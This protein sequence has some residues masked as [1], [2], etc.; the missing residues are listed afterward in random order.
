SNAASAVSPV[1]TPLTVSTP[2]AGQRTN[3]STP[4]LG[5]SAG[6]AAGDSTTV[7]ARVYQGASVA[8]TL[9]QTLSA[10]RVG[11]TWTIDATTLPDGQ[12]TVQAKQTDFTGATNT[13][14]AVTFN[15]DTTAAPV[16]LT[17]A[18]GTART[19]PYTAHANV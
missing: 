14:A 6:G 12:Y 16:T 4:T 3:D 7:T 13:T 15:V 18:N 19:F 10:T 9:L 5:G 11:A 1:D 17:S 8:G 2:T